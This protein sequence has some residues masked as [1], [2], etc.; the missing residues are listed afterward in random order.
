MA[1]SAEIPLLLAILLE[2]TVDEVTHSD[3]EGSTTI[4]GPFFIPGA[5]LLERPYALPQRPNQVGETLTMSGTV[6]GPG[7]RPLE[8]A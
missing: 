1:A 6:I 3:H 4:Q 5:P 7:G 2:A 8:D